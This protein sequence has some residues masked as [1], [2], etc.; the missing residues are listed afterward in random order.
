MTKLL[1]VIA[2][3]PVDGATLLRRAGTFWSLSSNQEQFQRLMEVLAWRHVERVAE[4]MQLRQRYLLTG[5]SD[6]V[7]R[8]YSEGTLEIESSPV[9][10]FGVLPQEAVGVAKIRMQDGQELVHGRDFVMTDVPGV[11]ELMEQIPAGNHLVSLEG[12]LI[13]TG[14]FSKF[15]QIVLKSKTDGLQDG[16]ALRSFVD[17]SQYDN[18]DERFRVLV[19]DMLG[20][21]RPRESQQV[22]DVRTIGDAVWVFGEK[23]SFRGLQGDT[24]IVTP[25]DW[26]E[27]GDDVFASLRHWDAAFERPPAWLSVL[28]VPGRYFSPHVEGVLEFSNNLEPVTVTI[29]DGKPRVTFPVSGDSRDVSAFF[30]FVRKREAELGYTLAEWMAGV[31]NP[32]T[33]QIPSTYSPVMALWGLWLRFGGSATFTSVEPTLDLIRRLQLIRRAVPPWQTHIV[34]FETE[35]P[36]A[37]L[38]LC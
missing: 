37:F 14:D 34:Q 26:L 4:V 22:V 19:G 31:E 27:P 21:F 2:E 38:S 11:I 29:V 28:K 33:Y 36:Q 8:A 24:A 7:Y 13:V 12:L 3:N 10:V 6:V 32:E 1:S 16:Y 23:E 20:V 25:G 15:W 17:Y 9:G 18:S 5:G 30:D 35:V